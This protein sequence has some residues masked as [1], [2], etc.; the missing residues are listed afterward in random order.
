MVYNFICIY[1]LLYSTVIQVWIYKIP[2]FFG[3]SV[4]FWD[5]VCSKSG[6]EYPAR[7]RIGAVAS[8]GLD[9]EST[10]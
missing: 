5:Y 4:A 7:N 6:A 10:A 2:H 8:K 3:E 1:H 9:L